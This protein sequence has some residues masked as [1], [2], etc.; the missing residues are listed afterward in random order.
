MNHA[1]P[2]TVAVIGASDRPDRY[3]YKAIQMLLEHGHCVYP[4]TPRNISLGDL[5][6]YPTFEEIPPPVHTITLYVNPSKLKPMVESIIH[7]PPQRIIFNPGTEHP[8]IAQHFRDAGFE[9]V[10]ACT[11]VML[12][13]HQFTD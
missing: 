12:S 1:T 3:A 9:V 13:T 4:V 6:I 2:L 8:Q 5:M 10:E 7:S 11:L